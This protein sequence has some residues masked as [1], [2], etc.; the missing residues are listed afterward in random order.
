MRTNG[1]FRIALAICVFFCRNAGDA[2]SLERSRIDDNTLG[3]A[4]SGIGAVEKTDSSTYGMKL[5]SLHPARVEISVADRLSVDLPGTYGGRLYLDTPSASGTLQ[6]RVLVDTLD[7][8][9]R[10]FSREYWIV[11]AGM[12]MWEGVINCYTEEGGRY[13]IVSLIQDKPIGKPGEEVGGRPLD[14]EALKVGF[15]RSLRDTTSE[16]V[17]QFDALLGSLQI[18]TSTTRNPR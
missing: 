16:N 1:L 9:G 11:Y 10:N 7:V 17:R 3:I 12:G 2:Q 14:G 8:G 13:Y 4:F 6:D 18:Q 15:L 5:K